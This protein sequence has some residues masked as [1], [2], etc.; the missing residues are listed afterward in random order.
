VNIKS[1]QVLLNSPVASNG[2]A[3]CVKTARFQVDLPATV[4]GDTIEFGLLPHFAVPVEATMMTTGSFVGSVTM[5]QESLFTAA[6]VGANPVRVSVAT[7]IGKNAGWT[8]LM[9]KGVAT[10]A[11]TAGRLTLTV[12]YAVG[13]LSL[14]TF[15]DRMVLSATPTP[16]PTPSV[17]ANGI[18]NDTAT[19]N[20]AD[21]WKD[22]A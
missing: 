21:I 16:S 12:S 20:D 10:G 2:L 11:G 22:A 4:A 14:L 9:V 15:E 18:W 7:S 3:S 6:T 13:D 17:F 1:Y 8:P 5:G 19:W